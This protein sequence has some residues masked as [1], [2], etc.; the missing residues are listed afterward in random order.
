VIDMRSKL[1]LIS[2][3]ILLSLV[4]TA[5][6]AAPAAAFTANATSGIGE[7]TIQFYDETNYST[8]NKFDNSGFEVSSPTNTYSGA[9]VIRSNT[10]AHTGS[11]SFR[12]VSTAASGDS[13]VGIRPT[14]QADRWGTS[15]YYYWEV[16]VYSPTG[17]TIQADRYSVVNFDGKP[18]FGTGK[19]DVTGG[20]H[21]I[22]AATWTK[23][24]G[25]GTTTAAWNTTQN[26]WLILRP[27][28]IDSTHYSTTTYLY[29]DDLITVP[30]TF[31]WDFG[32]GNTSAAVRPQNTYYSGVYDVSLTITHVNG[33]DVE[34]KTNYIKIA[35]GNGTSY[36]LTYP[37]VAHAFITE[38]SAPVTWTIDGV[39]QSET[40]DTLISTFT[41]P[42]NHYISAN[43]VDNWTVT[44]KR[45]LAVASIDTFNE[46]SYNKLVVDLEARDWEAV[47]ADSVSPEVDLIGD[48]FYLILFLLPFALI[49]KRQE[50]LTMPAILALIVG[51]VVIG[52]IPDT[53][54]LFVTLAVILAGVGIL[55]GMSRDRG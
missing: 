43:L 54:R 14:A 49:W 39:T 33:I 18:S 21:V 2:L 16:W 27:D 17:G 5:N 40:S 52:F 37:D 29:Y 7:K 22:P 48:S 6:A 38:E 25:Y 53:Y 36:I 13:F 30:V 11:Y 28:Y 19:I 50:S 34:T 20:V 26:S 35:G 8:I 45:S 9:A 15:T 47:A 4:G 32:D 44:V 3:F 51:I 23:I 41:E 1:I 24:Y 12:V 55:F 31:A 46:S 10:Y 42:G